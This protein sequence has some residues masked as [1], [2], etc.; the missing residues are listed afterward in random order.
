MRTTVLV[1]IACTLGRIEETVWGGKA[2]A[3]KVEV[4]PL[5]K[6][7]QNDIRTAQVK[8][9]LF[10]TIASCSRFNGRLVTIVFRMRRS[11]LPVLVVPRDTMPFL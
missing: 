1:G 7:A 6:T 9:I 11:K 4:E 5:A 3:G 8:Q 10:S 2:S